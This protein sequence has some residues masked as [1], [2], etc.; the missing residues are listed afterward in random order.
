MKRV[1]LNVD[2]S[3]TIKEQ[4]DKDKVSIVEIS[5][6]WLKALIVNAC[7]EPRP[8]QQGT[9]V[10]SRQP[11]MDEQEKYVK[12]CNCVSSVKDGIFVI[13][14]D[15]FNWMKEMFN[16]SKVPIQEGISEVIVGIKRAIDRAEVEVIN[17]KAKSE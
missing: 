15:T 8:N 13:E 4:L 1:D 9:I 11:T 5:G 10:P 16:K 14:D 3:K 17:E 6:N 2:V 7:N 12:V